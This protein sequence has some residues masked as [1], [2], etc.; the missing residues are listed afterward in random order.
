ML[1]ALQDYV[2]A[3]LSPERQL[4]L[5]HEDV[6]PED[7]VRGMCS[8][9]LGVHLAFLPEDVGG[10]GGGALDSYRIC[11]RMARLD[12]GVG[13]AVFASFLGCDPIM[14]GGT[15][16]QQKEWLGRMA[17]QGIVFAYGATEP[18]AGSNLGG[19]TTTATPVETD[20]RVT[21]YRLNGRKQWIS[22]GSIADAYT[23][24]AAAPAGPTWFVVERGT[25]GFTSAPPEDKHGIRLSNT[26]ALFLDDVFVPVDRLVGGV[27]G[28]GMTQA[29]EVF[30]YTRLMVAAF[31]LG[32]GWAALDRAIEF[33]KN[34][35]QGG[36]VLSRKQGYTHKLIVPHVV[37]LEAARS[38]SE[39]IACRIDAGE[40]VSSLYTDSAIA[41]YLATEAGNAAA[42]AAIQ[43]HGGYGYTRPYLVEKIKRDLRVTTI[44]EGT[45]EVMQMAIVAGR[46]QQHLR[47]KGEHYLA[48]A[49]DL[50]ALHGRHPEVGAGVVALAARSLA[51]L[52]TAYRQARLTRNQH[53]MFRLAD[54][55]AKTETAASFARR[56]AATADGT[57]SE[58]VDT[59]F[60]APTLAAMSRVYARSVAATC[61][62]EAQRWMVGG[63]EPG[64]A[65]PA[66]D[67]LLAA[68]PVDAALAAQA[69]LLHDLDAVADAIYDRREG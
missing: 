14:V 59:R 21:G 22:N 18:D 61:V 12:P 63:V 8:D 5:D 17:E 41:K 30:G 25:P 43:A 37:A 51:T 31:G 38:L 35:V 58:K 50:E 6:C 42:D 4:D 53:L 3:A 54:L 32:G 64:A 33:S 10:M 67:D 55:I 1:E 44:Y 66:L 20:G 2:T 19:L 24:L 16:E 65:S 60:D 27:E 69:G 28:E 34:R 9:D 11:E 23:I 36:S 46:W 40:S 45:S 48:V 52:M 49:A 56:A 39:E 47:T 7:I 29:G 13:T 62:E 68:L 15:P 26:A 57:L